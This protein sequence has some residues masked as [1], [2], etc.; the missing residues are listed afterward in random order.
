M[1]L[2]T[3]NQKKFLLTF[4]KDE[5]YPGWDNIANA[6]LDTGGC[7]VAGKECIWKG[8]IGNFIKT[9]EAK[10]TVG[11]LLYKFDLSYFLSSE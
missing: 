1:N 10:N 2:L 7:I 8:G 9:S 4:F 5:T 6:L 3:E 11:C